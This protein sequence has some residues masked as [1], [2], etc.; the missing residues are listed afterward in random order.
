MRRVLKLNMFGRQD[1]VAQQGQLGVPQGRPVNGS[2]H[3]DLDIQQI[4]EQVLTFPVDGVP[5]TRTAAWP[6]DSCR[7]R[8]GELV[9]RS[10]HNHH[11]VVGITT[12]VSKGSS[13][14][15]MRQ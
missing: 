7:A 4:A 2:D 11:L 13:K 10:G 8:T 15:A 1:D 3:G 14:L 9:T 6:M 12:D 5:G